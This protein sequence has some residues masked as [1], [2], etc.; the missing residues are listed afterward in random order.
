MKK[1]TLTLLAIILSTVSMAAAQ[2]RV[3]SA[4]RAVDLDQVVRKSFPD[5]F[6][7][8]EYEQLLNNDLFPIG[9]SRDG[10]F[11]YVEEPVDDACGCYFAEVHIVDL[12]TDRSL[13]RSTM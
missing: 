6:G 10:K 12:R 11:A 5:Y 2:G 9:W 8:Q 4:P 13:R 3:Y 7:K 1:Q